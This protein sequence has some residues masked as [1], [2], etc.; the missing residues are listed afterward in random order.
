MDNRKK[1]KSTSGRG[2]L[3]MTALTLSVFLGWHAVAEPDAQ[4]GATAGESSPIS[5]RRTK[6]AAGPN[7]NVWQLLGIAEDEAKH[8]TDDVIQRTKIAAGANMRRLL[9]I[10][11]DEAK[12]STDDG[13][14]RAKM[15]ADRNVWQLLG[16]AEDEAKHSADDMTL[17][18]KVVA[19]ANANARQ[20]LERIAEGGATHSAD[21]GIGRAKMTADHN[22]E[23]S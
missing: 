21:D 1:N 5:E 19:S 7:A 4:G 11:E 9:G 14:G 3:L 10:A 16:I 8:S 20:L 23:C 18:A 22:A 13:I 17:H 2:L 6:V 15:T 12:H